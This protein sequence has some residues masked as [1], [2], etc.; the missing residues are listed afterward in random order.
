MAQ[1][2]RLVAVL[3]VL[4]SWTTQQVT[5]QTCAAVTGRYQPKMGSGY[6]SAVIATGLQQ[7]RHIV[8]DTAGNLLVAEGGSGSVRRLV[9]KEQGETVCVAS[10]T[11][12]TNDRSTNHGISLSA[13]GKTLF[14]S[15]LSSVTAY[16]YDATSGKVGSGKVIISGMSNQGHPTRALLVSKFNP[17]VIMVARGSNANIDTATTSQSAGR[18]MIKSFSISRAT[19]T[20]IDYV[21]GGEVLGWGLRNI[22]GMGEDPVYGG[23]WSVENSMD[24][25]HLNSKDVH[26]ENPAEKLNY[27]GIINETNNRYKGANFGYPSCVAAWDTQLLG[28]SSLQVGSLFKPDG[29]PQASDCAQHEP[30]RLHFHSHTAPLDLKFNA[31]ATSAYITFHGSWDRNPPDGY[32]VM[33]VDFNNGQPVADRTSKTAQIPVMENSNTGACPNSCFRPVGL[34]FDNKGRLYMSSDSSGEIYVIYGA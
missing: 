28:V 27:H 5:A 23:V 6:K 7:P 34:A 14:T 26:N 9:L 18:S 4:W 32:R 16:S 20:V 17:D 15:S 25:V 22:V 24:D 31:N 1:I 2:G 11:A 33:R 29:V 30:G 8:V 3:V 12:V 10:N 19:S 13:D 21:S